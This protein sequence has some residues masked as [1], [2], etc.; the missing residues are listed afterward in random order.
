MENNRSQ[1]LA[2]EFEAKHQQFLHIPDSLFTELNLLKI[3][4]AGYEREGMHTEEEYEILQTALQNVEAK[5]QQADGR[6]YSFF[7]GTFDIREVQSEMRENEYIVRYV[8]AEENLYAYILQKDGI[9]ILKLGNKD[10]LLSLTEQYYETIKNKHH[11]YV[12]QAIELYAVLIEPLKLPLDSLKN[13]V[14][15]PDNKLNY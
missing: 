6:H 8:V 3:E 12:G 5:M 2:K 14:I 1:H 7:G 9:S 11:D 13:L 4:L 15:I 10:T